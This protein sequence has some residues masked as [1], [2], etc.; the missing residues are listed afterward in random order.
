[1]RPAWALRDMGRVGG[2]KGRQRGGRKKEQEEGREGEM[3]K[4]S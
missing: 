1:M 2:K 4:V 3:G